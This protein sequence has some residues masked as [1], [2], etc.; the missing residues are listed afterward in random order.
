MHKCFTV[1]VNLQRKINIQM[2]TRAVCARSHR[3]YC[4]LQLTECCG[5]CCNCPM[6]ACEKWNQAWKTHSLFAIFRFC[7]PWWRMCFIRW[8]WMWAC[9]TL[10]AISPVTHIHTQRKRGTDTSFAGIWAFGPI[11]NEN[12]RNRSNTIYELKSSR[13][14]YRFNRGNLTI[15]Y[16]WNTM[17]PNDYDF[18]D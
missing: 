11:K 6:C 9:P 14:R 13:C 8:A 15:C 10:V 3:H 5:H 2:C 12:L 16:K 17:P 1:A 4:A 7:I 18:D